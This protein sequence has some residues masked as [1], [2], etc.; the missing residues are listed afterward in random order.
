[1]DDSI[2]NNT[3]HNGE[4][5]TLA[6]TSALEV[7]S[8]EVQEIIGRP[9]HWLVRWGITAFFGVLGLVLLSAWAIKYPETINA[10]VKL[11]AINAPK[12]V[13][14]RIEGK[15]VRLLAGNNTRVQKGQVLGWLESTASHRQVLALSSKIDSMR[16]W[17]T[18]GKLN[19]FHNLR[20]DGY[21]DLGELQNAFQT[22][23]QAWR[24]FV[25]Y[26]PGRFYSRKKRLLKQELTYN[27]M[28]LKQLKQQKEL[29]QSDV[30]LSQKEYH[31]KKKLAEKNLVA[32]LEIARKRGDL[33]AARL[34]LLQTE[35][36][37]IR[38]HSQQMVKK[39]KLMELN[40][41]MAQQKSIFLQALNSLQSA[42]EAWEEKYLLTAP[43]SGKFIY[44]G[45]LQ[46]NQTL[47]AGQKVGYIQP[48]NTHF[49]GEV[50]ISQHSFGKINKGQK[51]LVRFSGY[52]YQEF[53][54]VEGRLDYLSAMP[55]RDSI[56][57]GKVSF[58]KGFT[59]N[60]GKK[61]SPRNGLMGQAQ[62]ITEDMTL[63]ERFYNNIAKQI[64]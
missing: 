29:Q 10:P 21:S 51:V 9:P 23:E 40:K 49:F 11:T 43:V 41:Q 37:I 36:A 33:R 19:K 7:R 8:A 3:P 35:S 45:I 2:I 24:T 1:M 58:P 22:F 50:M 16:K 6:E 14:S 48:D 54:S 28:L 53:G 55:V 27:Q 52:P 12:T 32:P 13:Q 63:L 57:V 44:G 34:P 56:F 15:L 30:K 5:A 64:R 39:Q 26:Q 25:S 60:Y 47:R 38:N 61:L 59:T 42:T 17:L 20:F 31:A 18:S 4:E 62:I 46:E